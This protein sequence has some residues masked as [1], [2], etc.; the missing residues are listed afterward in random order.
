MTGDNLVLV[1]AG[2]TGG[3]LF[4]AQALSHALIARGARVRL[5]T[6]ERALKYG[7]DFPAEEIHEIASATPTAG[8]FM[9]KALAALTLGKGVIEAYA[10][11]G[12]IKP[13]VV[14]AFGGY[15]TVPPA[16][17][18]S[19]RAIPLILHE[20]NAVMG[21]ANR[22]LARRADKIAC[23]FPT[24]DGLPEGLR[25]RVTQVG[26]PVRPAVLEAAALPYPDF[27]DGRLRLLVTGGS[28]G[29]RIMSDVTPAAVGLLTPEQRSRLVIVQQARG[30]D[31]ARVEDAYQRLNVT[32]E[33]APFFPD[34]PLRMAQAHLVLGRSGAS[35]VSELAVIGRPAILVPFPHALDADQAANARHL[36]KT[37]AAEVMRQT[38]FTPEWL[39]GRLS[40][41]LDDPKDLTRR[42]Q[43]AK[44]AG[45]PDAAQ[46]LADLALKTAGL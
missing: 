18:A 3:H 13:R 20:Q 29:A 28:Q 25:G 6:D 27:A 42:A 11:L 33:A 24:L 1:A 30:E 31:L 5:A 37:G 38:G 12:K 43:A 44:S 17:A 45:I 34:L 21:R 4:P 41:A 8:G 7:G 9:A 2:G 14:V 15:P 10:L 23:G 35:T 22:F 19:L 39:A 32:C 16:L 26:N 36:E 40:H 46:R